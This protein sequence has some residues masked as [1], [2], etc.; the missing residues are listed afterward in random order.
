RFYARSESMI[1]IVST[2]QRAAASAQRLF[3]ILDKAPSVPEP[4]RPVH[5]GRLKGAVELRGVR[6]R[7]GAR[8]VLHG[9]DLRIEPGEMIGLVGHSGAG[10]TTL[11]NLLC[12]FYD[13]ASGA[14]LVDGT[15]VRSFPRAEYR[16][17]I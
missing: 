16:H 2:T 15:D 14:V 8:E 9:L 13:V 17:N 10:K 11:L 7:Y 12:R 1:R 6:F 4:A 3:E 5:P